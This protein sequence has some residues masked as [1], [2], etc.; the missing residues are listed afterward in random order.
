MYQK[1]FL[2]QRWESLFELGLVSRKEKVGKDV[3]NRITELNQCPVM[4]EEVERRVKSGKHFFFSLS[5]PS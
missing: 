1:S 4:R 2:L 3:Q 5:F